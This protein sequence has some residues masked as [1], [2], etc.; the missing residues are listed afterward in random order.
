[1]GKKHGGMATLQFLVFFGEVHISYLLLERV[2]LALKAKD[3][4]I[5]NSW[6]LSVH[7]FVAL[8]KETTICSERCRNKCQGHTGLRTEDCDSVYLQ[9]VRVACCMLGLR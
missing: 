8:K 2:T 5:S 4:F 9:A 3:R 6:L 7:L 1:V